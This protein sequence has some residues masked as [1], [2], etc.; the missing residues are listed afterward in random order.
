MKRKTNF[1]KY[2]EEQIKDPKFKEHFQEAG[3]GQ[4]EKYNGR[5]Y[6]S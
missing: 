1:D 3:E 5:P 4:I 2:L 6:Y